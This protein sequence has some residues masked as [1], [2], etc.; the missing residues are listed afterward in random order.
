M[1]KT[2]NL[3]TTT[4]LYGREDKKEDEGRM[5][6]NKKSISGKIKMKKIVIFPS[7]VRIK[8]FVDWLTAAGR[9]GLVRYGIFIR[10][11]CFPIQITCFSPYIFSY[12]WVSLSWRLR[13]HVEGAQKF[14]FRNE[15]H[16]PPPQH[17]HG[18]THLSFWQ[19]DY[20]KILPFAVLLDVRFSSISESHFKGRISLHRIIGRP[21][22]THIR[23]IS[24]LFFIHFIIFKHFSNFRFSIH[25]VTLAGVTEEEDEGMN[26]IN[27][28]SQKERILNFVT[29][30]SVSQFCFREGHTSNYPQLIRWRERIIGRQYLWWGS[31]TGKI[32]RIVS[33]WPFR[34]QDAALP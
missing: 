23:I 28:K 19:I 10:R 18:W 5:A 22:N 11:G 13:C 26:E 33:G 12:V 17:T 9:G 29:F 14:I 4:I 15:P 30:Y 34:W 1:R 16:Q 7:Y 20:V 6:T 24:F 27:S 21:F 3:L 2:H 25:N 32:L 31:N 8:A